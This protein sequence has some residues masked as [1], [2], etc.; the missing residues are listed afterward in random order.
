[1]LLR[2]NESICLTEVRASD[3]AAC[4]EYLNDRE[5]AQYLLRVPNPYRGED[6]DAW[7]AAIAK[8]ATRNGGRTTT[9]AIRDATD[10][11][12]G[13]FGFRDLDLAGAQEGE[14]GYWLARPY[15][16][17]GIMSAVVNAGCAYGFA[18]FGLARI[19]AKVFEFNTGSARLLEKCG[20]AREGLLRAEYVKDGRSIDAI[21]YAKGREAGA[22]S[23]GE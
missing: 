14:I 18:E 10:R 20:F 5:V 12:V 22:G 9:F 17:R 3:K 2:V 4:V 19:T 8:M 11:K 16:R 13:G 21:L 7:L 6:F 15:W 1:M 23:A